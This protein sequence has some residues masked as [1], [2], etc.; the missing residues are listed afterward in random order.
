MG[1]WY[2]YRQTFKDHNVDF[3]QFLVLLKH[4]LEIEQYICNYNNE[5][6]KFNRKWRQIVE[7]L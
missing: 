2:I 6:D 4:K 7:Q 3:Y 5:I 1:K